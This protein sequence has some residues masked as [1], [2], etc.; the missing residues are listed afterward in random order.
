VDAAALALTVTAITPEQTGNLV[1]YPA[2]APVPLASTLN[3]VAGQVIANTSIVLI[4]P[5]AGDAFAIFNNSDGHTA[6]VVDVVGYMRKQQAADCGK[7]TVSQSA[8]G[9]SVATVVATC[10]VGYLPVGGGCSSDTALAVSWLE[11]RSTANGL[12]FSCT[13]RNVS[14]AGISITTDT[15][16]CRKAGH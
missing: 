13:A 16:C 3:F 1:A 10:S 12:G 7:E 14:G 15:L 6:L 9:N 8:A 4:S 2:G 5:G 11:R